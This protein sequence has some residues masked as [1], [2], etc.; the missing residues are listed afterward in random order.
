MKLGIDG[1]YLCG[2]RTGMGT[3]LINILEHWQSD[4]FEKTVL[5]LP[6]GS[7]EIPEIA[8]RIGNIEIC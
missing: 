4:A 5:F 6:G 1:Y 2:K 7:R 8:A 3:T